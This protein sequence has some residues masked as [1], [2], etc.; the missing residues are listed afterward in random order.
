MNY[1]MT[2]ESLQCGT[3]VESSWGCNPSQ[4]VDI[5]VGGGFGLPVLHASVTIDASVSYRTDGS[6]SHPMKLLT[7]SP[8]LVIFIFTNKFKS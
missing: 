4:G 3:E 1:S 7:Q 6:L 8:P 5:S 2:G